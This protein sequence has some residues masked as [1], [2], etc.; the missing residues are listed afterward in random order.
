MGIPSL[1][2][3]RRRKIA[4]ACICPFFFFHD[5]NEDGFN[6]TSFCW[7]A[8]ITLLVFV[9][10]IAASQ[11]TACGQL[12]R[13]PDRESVEPIHQLIILLLWVLMISACA[14][15]NSIA[16]RTRVV[17]FNL[18]FDY[19]RRCVKCGG[20]ARWN[21]DSAAI[22]IEMKRAISPREVMKECTLFWSNTSTTTRLFR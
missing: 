22:W 20:P 21:K 5:H 10:Y 6:Q 17:Q 12:V 9:V 13:P 14:Q 18:P 16:D 8:K 15:L 4:A 19:K 2:P 7:F 11:S 1:G 3:G